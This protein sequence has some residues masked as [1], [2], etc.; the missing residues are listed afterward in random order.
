MAL[1]PPNLTFEAAAAV[2]LAALTALQGLRDHGNVH[3]GQKVL[4]NGAGGGVGTFAVQIAK[5]FDADVTAVCSARNLDVARSIGADH[6]IDYAEED[7]TRSGRR[8]DVILAVNGYQPILHYRRALTPG[9]IC[10]VLGGSAG[11]LIQGMFLGPLFLRGNKKFRGMMTRPAQK[12]LIVL[13]DLLEAG[14]VVPVID[15]RYALADAAEAIRY[16]MAGHAR[17]KVV[18]TVVPD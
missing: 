15:R 18:I 16:L 2:P 9:G 5:C 11:Q 3:A 10:V 14:K 17:G 7:F 8:Y 1:K 6:V 12:D 4:I 13:K